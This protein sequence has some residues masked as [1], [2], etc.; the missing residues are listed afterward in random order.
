[1][2]FAGAN[3]Y[4]KLS[5]P[6]CW[7]SPLFYSKNFSS[8]TLLFKDIFKKSLAVPHSMW[9][10]N[11]LTRDRTLVSCIGSG[12]LPTG[13]PGKSYIFKILVCSLFTLK[14]IRSKKWLFKIHIYFL[15][16]IAC[17]AFMLRKCHHISTDSA[18]SLQDLDPSMSGKQ[19]NDIIWN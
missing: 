17:Q 12:V 8:S 16:F 6:W 10:L 7:S 19:W 14:A 2:A 5:H 11:S 4:L 18:S 15:T 9:D 3:L 13:L 1:M